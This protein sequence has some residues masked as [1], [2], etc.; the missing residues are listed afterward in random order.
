MDDIGREGKSV[1]FELARL[2]ELIEEYS[3]VAIEVSEPRYKAGHTAGIF[4][5][6]LDELSFF[7]EAVHP[8]ILRT[9]TIC[10]LCVGGLVLSTEGGAGNQH[11]HDNPQMFNHQSGPRFRQS[12]YRVTRLL[13]FTRQYIPLRFPKRPSL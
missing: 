8:G 12:Y 6:N 2:E 13:E 5:R 10:R 9:G 4:H 11:R 3:L 7:E 1:P